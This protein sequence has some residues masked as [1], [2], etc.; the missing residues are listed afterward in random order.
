MK[1]SPAGCFSLHSLAVRIGRIGLPPRPW[2]GRV[3]P[4]NH[5]RI[6]STALYRLARHHSICLGTQS[7]VSQDQEYLSRTLQ[8]QYTFW[9]LLRKRLKRFSSPGRRYPIP[10]REHK[11]TS[12]FCAPARTRTWND[13]SEDSSDIH[14]TTGAWYEHNTTG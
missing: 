14:F 1:N 11:R 8:V 9:L 4:L 12:L 5:I 2:Q 10:A 13:C 6:L 7:S 3:L